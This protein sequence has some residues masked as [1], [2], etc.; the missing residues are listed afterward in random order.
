MASAAGFGRLRRQPASGGGGGRLRA[1]AAAVFGQRQRP[2]LGGDGGLLPVQFLVGRK[3]NI[4]CI[5]FRELIE[6]ASGAHIHLS[7]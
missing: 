2:S 7:K 1:A 4:F 5:F 6:L 3:K